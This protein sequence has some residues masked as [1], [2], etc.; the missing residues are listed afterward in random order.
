MNGVINILKPP[1]VSSNGVTVFLR[2]L[3]GEKRVGHAGTLD[4]G[5]AGVLVVLVGRSTR[6]SDYLMGHDKRYIAEMRLGL[7][8]D[9]GDSYG[10]VTGEKPPG[11]VSEARLEEAFSG[12]IGRIPQTP[13]DYSAVKV[14]G[15]KSYELA[16][17]GISVK[18]KSRLVEVKSL[19]LLRRTG[20]ASFLI[21]IECG[22]GTY[23]RTLLSD[24]AASL[25][26]LAYTSFLF[27]E[28]SGKYRAAEA[29]TLLE[30][31]DM[32]ERGDLSFLEPP[33]QALYDMPLIRL[34][35]DRAF[36]LEHGLPAAAC[37]EAETVRV[38]CGDKFYGIGKYADN[39]V[40]LKVP[41]D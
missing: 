3:F 12:F 29:H 16:R 19:K 33:E 5:A 20:E 2:K 26:E 25:G 40:R 28:A 18:K 9:T 39:E 34:G 30:V 15:R 27:R 22:K 41:L 21:G 23:I 24:I 31:R 35:E 6:L 7:S 1:G 13:P 32:Y 14:E 11:Q 4:P 38:Y 37:S 10:R 17:K 36:A 8:T